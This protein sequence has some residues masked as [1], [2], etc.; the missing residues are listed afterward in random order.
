MTPV[1]Y[2]LY[3]CRDER[4]AFIK[5][6]YEEKLF[7]QP[8]CNNPQEVL[9]DIEQSIYNHSLYDLLQASAEAQAFGVDITDP[10]PTSVSVVLF[11]TLVHMSS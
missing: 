11:P 1:F 5:A 4:K 6:K 2:L 7:V 10:L 3:F 8:L 9:S